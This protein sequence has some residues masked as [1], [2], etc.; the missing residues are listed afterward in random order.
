MFSS[1]SQVMGLQIGICQPDLVKIT[2]I[3]PKGFLLFLYVCICVWVC[4]H[5]RRYLQQPKKDIWPPRLCLCHPVWALGGELPPWN[6]NKCPLLLYLLFVNFR[7]S[8]LSPACFCFY[9]YVYVVPVMAHIWSW[10]V[11]TAF[12]SQFSPCILELGGGIHVFI[13]I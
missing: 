3:F 1:A 7:V 10:E 8:L 5:A 12:R 13:L 2:C 6:S 11:D 4:T 9:M